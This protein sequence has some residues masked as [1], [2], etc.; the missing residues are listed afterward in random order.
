M[1]PETNKTEKTELPSQNEQSL[2]GVV[3]CHICHLVQRLP[4]QTSPDSVP[5]CC[6][7]E[8]PLEVKDSNVRIAWSRQS[9]LA[10]LLCY[11]LA[12]TL[13]ALRFE[14]FGHVSENSIVGSIQTLFTD[15]YLGLGI[16]VLLCSVLIPL[17]KLIG[18]WVVCSDSFLKTRHRAQTYKILEWSGRWGMIDVLLVAVL[19]ALLKVGELVNVYPG[20]G[21]MLFAAVVF[22][23]LLASYF[24][25]PRIVWER[26][27][28]SAPIH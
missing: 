13:P 25:H 1:K 15:G 27:D 18:I 16:I 22:L 2:S 26:Q 20:P 21:A 24:F 14:R 8:T 9:A 7:C 10:A 12:I 17:C 6:R 3:S 4:E 5:V 19:V 11:P 23:S 28:D